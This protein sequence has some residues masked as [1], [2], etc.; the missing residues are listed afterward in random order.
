MKYILLSLLALNLFAY[1]ENSADCYASATKQF[2][3]NSCAI[4]EEK[5]ANTELEN[6]YNLLLSLYKDD[7]VFIDRLKE[8]QANW[9]KYKES[10]IT[11]KY[12]HSA[13]PRYY[14]SVFPMCNH[15]YSA[16]IT[17]ARILELKEWLNGT[18][19]GEVCSGSQKN[20]SSLKEVPK[21]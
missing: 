20:E 8:S 10:Q 2:E 9:L 16:R 7:P 6:T 11:M 5:I 17:S 13:E 14:G 21:K 4:N 15:S 3:L 12:P 18:E 1:A 19:E